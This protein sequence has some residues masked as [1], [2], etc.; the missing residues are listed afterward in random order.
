M[1]LL[2][3]KLRA[4]PERFDA[5]SGRER[6][7]IL[8]LVL[9]MLGGGWFNLLWYPQNVLQ[10]QIRSDIQ[11]LDDQ[12]ALLD[13]QLTGLVNQAERDPNEKIKQELEQLK[14]FISEMEGQIKGTA[15]AL[16]EPREMAQLLEQMLLSNAGLQLV[17]LSTLKTEPLMGSKPGDVEAGEAPAIDDPAGVAEKNIYRHAFVIEFE[18]RYLAVL[19]YLKALEAL[20][21]RFFWDGIE[22]EVTDYPAARVRLQLHTLSLSEGWIG[23]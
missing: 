6:G 11:E 14:R 1:S 10:K 17:R 15:A 13:T 5:L 21:G 22:L 12:I 3:E 16:I 4:L 19:N 2:E 23:V 18:G 9:A 7:M 8:I 20:P